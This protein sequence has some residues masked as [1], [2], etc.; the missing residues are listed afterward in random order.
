MFCNRYWTLVKK[1]PGKQIPGCVLPLEDDTILEL[2]EDGMGYL[3]PVT[4]N[5]EDL[6]LYCLR[7]PVSADCRPPA[8]AAYPSAASKPQYSA[9]DLP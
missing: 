5:R 4:P 2:C 7:Q 3:W 8:H 6:C 9:A 1:Q